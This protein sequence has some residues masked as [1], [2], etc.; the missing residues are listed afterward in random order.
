MLER[1]AE[2]M[3]RTPAPSA[4]RLGMVA[5]ALQASIPLGLFVLAEV[6]YSLRIYFEYSYLFY[7]SD[8]FVAGGF[9]FYFLTFERIFLGNIYYGFTIVDLIGNLLPP[10]LLT[11]LPLVGTGAIDFVVSRRTTQA[12]GSLRAGLRM[13]LWGHAG[14]IAALLA[15]IVYAYRELLFGFGASWASYAASFFEVLALFLLVQI[16]LALGVS[17]IVGRWGGRQG[18]IARGGTESDVALDS[19]DLA[20]VRDL[21]S[22]SNLGAFVRVFTPLDA[23]TVILRGVGLIVFFVVLLLAQRFVFNIGGGEPFATSVVG[24]VGSIGYMVQGARRRG[25]PIHQFQD[26]LVGFAEPGC[27]IAIR[28]DEMQPLSTRS[29]LRVT[30][31]TGDQIVV[32]DTLVHADELKDLIRQTVTR[33]AMSRQ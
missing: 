22:R 29:P 21:A 25:Q 12:T 14:Y 4:R 32:P 5:A 3:M 10:F 27:L 17:Q 13:C 30:S 20:V 2:D 1:T 18:L 26:G 16:G 8:L 33:V 24:V 15:L 11:L 9:E 7:Y 6:L 31:R 23:A 28:W 19:V